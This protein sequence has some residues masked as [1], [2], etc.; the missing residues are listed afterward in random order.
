MNKPFTDSRKSL[1][2]K[3][4]NRD[5]EVGYSKP[6]KHSRFKPGQSGNPG[7]RPRGAKNKKSAL[8]EERL[9]T[10][11]LEEAY[12][13]IKVNDGPNQV[14]VP[15]AQAVV[16]SLAHNAVKGNTTAQRL[17]AEMLASTEAANA[18]MMQELFESAIDYK[19]NWNAELKRREQLGIDAPSPIPHPDD[20]V[21]NARTGTV[22]FKGPMTE[23]EKQTWDMLI[24]KRHECYEDIEEYQKDIAAS[25][26]E[27]YKL[28]LEDEIR[29]T[30]RI[31]K[32]IDSKIGKD[33]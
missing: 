30:K 21:L 29:H 24:Q 14:S 1:T 11:I 8:N 9:K 32:I 20:V 22:H 33:E 31:I 7:G 15:M 16:R 23:E 10:I 2:A 3:A 28:F 17:F 13:M 12:R 25:D 19:Q 4:N 18:K 27:E 6:P 5:Y 26:S